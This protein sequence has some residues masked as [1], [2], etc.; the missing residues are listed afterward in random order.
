MSSVECGVDLLVVVVSVVVIG[1]PVH[2]RP[3]ISN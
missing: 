3:N 1:S 2:I